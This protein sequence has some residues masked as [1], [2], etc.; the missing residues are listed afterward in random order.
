MDHCHVF[1]VIMRQQFLYVQ[2]IAQNVDYVKKFVLL[3]K[4]LLIVKRGNVI[5]AIGV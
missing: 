4:H 5:T 3:K 2:K 1:A